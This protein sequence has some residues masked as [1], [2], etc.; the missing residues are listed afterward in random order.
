MGSR[1]GCHIPPSPPPLRHSILHIILLRAPQAAELKST[2]YTIDL[3]R[4]TLYIRHNRGEMQTNVRLKRP[5]ACRHFGQLHTPATP[6][7]RWGSFGTFHEINHAVF[8]ACGF[9]CLLC[10]KTEP[11]RRKKGASCTIG[12]VDELPYIYT[13][14]VYLCWS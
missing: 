10:T 6:G 14:H 5:V 7:P 3:E 1:P 13:T 2:L 12:T 9:L 4:P 8:R 11:R